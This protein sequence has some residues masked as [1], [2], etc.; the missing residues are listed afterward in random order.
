MMAESEV[1]EEVKWRKPSNPL[2]VSAWRLNGLICTGE[3]YKDKGKL[4]V[5]KGPALDNPEGLFNGSLE[6]NLQQRTT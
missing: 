6:V 4:T 3:T 5:A 1:N 2:G